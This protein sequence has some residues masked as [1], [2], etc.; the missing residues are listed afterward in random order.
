MR[1]TVS[2]E[3]EAAL[4]LCPLCG[5]DRAA[6]LFVKNG[7]RIV[8]C[9]ACDVAYVENRPSRHEI[10]EIY[11][12]S[13][14]Y[15]RDLA[16][17]GSPATARHATAA[18]RYLDLI[19]AHRK[20]GRILDVGCSVGIFLDAARRSGW[21]VYGVEFS[22]DTAA[23]ARAS[24][25]NVLTGTLADTSFPNEFFDVVTLWDVLEHLSDPLETLKAINPLLTNN[26]ILGL[27]TPNV[28]GLFPRLS[29]ALAGLAGVWP[30]PEPP[31]HLFQF[32]K[33]TLAQVLSGSGFEAV[34]VV[35]RRIPLTYTFGTPRHVMRSAR[36]LGYAA[37][38]APIA[39]IGPLL[40][41]GD[42]VDVVARKVLSP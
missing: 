32:S 22:K 2:S 16:D 35:D 41:S 31:Y 7:Y 14:G 40:N 21:E 29:L 8:R 9:A 5:A 25:L 1:T 10:A 42:Q 15:H 28:D 34:R 20:G 12:F 4:S 37:I 27:S 30:H 39:L 3:Q 17:P 18:K 36:R 38:F 24:G 6:V 26:G 13:S 19:E 11:S 33:E 23:L